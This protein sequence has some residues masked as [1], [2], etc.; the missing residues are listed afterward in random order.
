MNVADSEM[1]N[2]ATATG[3]WLAQLWLAI[4]TACNIH[5]GAGQISHAHA[6]KCVGDGIY[7]RMQIDGVVIAAKLRLHRVRLELVHTNRNKLVPNVDRGGMLRLTKLARILR[8]HQQIGQSLI[9]SVHVY[10][11]PVHA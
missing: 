11:I 3:T 10:N 7:F 1:N 4:L 2:G 5:G 6:A 9:V 8:D